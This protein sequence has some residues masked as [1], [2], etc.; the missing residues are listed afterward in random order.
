MFLDVVPLG[1][2]EDFA[3]SVCVFCEGLFTIV[4]VGYNVAVGIVKGVCD[5]SEESAA[6]R[7]SA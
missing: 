7:A 6:E 5:D 1:C 2:G 3:Q 4:P